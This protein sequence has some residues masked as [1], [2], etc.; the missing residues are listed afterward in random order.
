MFSLVKCKGSNSIEVFADGVSI[1][2]IRLRNKVFILDFALLA[3]MYSLEEVEKWLQK[4]IKEMLSMF[5]DV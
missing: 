3:E 4:H 2:V 5:F 1:A